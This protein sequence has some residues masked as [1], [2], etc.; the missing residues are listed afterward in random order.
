MNV[1][2][3]KLN[4][5]SPSYYEWWLQIWGIEEFWDCLLIC[6][7]NIRN[8][9]ELS[10]L[11]WLTIKLNDMALEFCGAGWYDS[12][13]KGSSFYFTTLTSFYLNFRGKFF[14]CIVLYHFTARY[15]HP[16]SLMPTY[17]TSKLD[18]WHEWN[19]LPLKRGQ[20]C[21]RQDLIACKNSSFW[22]ATR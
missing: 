6:L 2:L 21:L 14:G 3:I 1:T 19:E 17:W 7:Y 22:S 16:N 15:G 5:P 20:M 12:T 18:H 11:Q 4:Y 9:Y 13:S 10:E 8:V